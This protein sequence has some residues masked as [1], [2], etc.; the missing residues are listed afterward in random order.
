M[1]FW[2]G[3]EDHKGKVIETKLVLTAK[4]LTQCLTAVL[5]PAVT[6]GTIHDPGG[7]YTGTHQWQTPR[8]ALDIITAAF[9]VEYR[10]NGDGTLD[11]GTPAQLY[12]TTA[13]DSIITAHGRRAGHGR[14]VPRAARSTPTSP[15]S[16]TRP[17]WCCS[18]RPPTP[19][20]TRRQFAEATA[21]RPDGALQGH[22]RQPGRSSPG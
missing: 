15:W 5:P 16:T 4:T 17:G 21:E 8:D 3:D 19:A 14:A 13:P 1:L 20:G 6:L 7:T 11:V 2:L 12:N 9:G 10:V 18:G 22:A